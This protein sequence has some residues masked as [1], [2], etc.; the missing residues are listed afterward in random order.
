[1]SLRIWFQAIHG[2][3]A[4]KSGID[5]LP[6]ILSFVVGSILSGGLVTAIGY[7]TPFLILGSILAGVGTGLVSTFKTNSG[8][9]KWISYQIICG[10]GMGMGV[11]QPQIANQAVLD[12]KDVPTGTSI[13]VFVQ[14]LGTFILSVFSFVRVLTR[15]P[16]RRHPLHLHRPKRIHQQTRREPQK[17]CP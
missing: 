11:Q 4:V 5:I 3:S 14:T 8:S 13:V 16:R 2:V 6:M 10:L 7:Y 15:S 9:G 1:M 12:M 17:T